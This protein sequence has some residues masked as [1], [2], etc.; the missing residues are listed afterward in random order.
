[1]QLV[2]VVIYLVLC[3]ML[4]IAGRRSRIGSF[5]VFLCSVIC[6]PLL[7]GLTFALLRPFP[8]KASSGSPADS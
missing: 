5:G 1:M 8:K 7:V 3:L 4:A 2:P 6:T